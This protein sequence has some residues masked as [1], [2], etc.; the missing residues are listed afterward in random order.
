MSFKQIGFFAEIVN[1]LKEMAHMKKILPHILAA[2]ALACQVF[3]QGS[4]APETS[5]SAAAPF[6]AEIGKP[7]E[8]SFA[9]DIPDGWHIYGANP[10]ELGAP[11]QIALELPR[12]FSQTRTVWPPERPFDFMGVKSWGYSGKI[13]IR[14]EL[15]AGESAKTGQIEIPVKISMLQC[16]DTCVP[17]EKKLALKFWLENPAQSAASSRPLESSA[18]AVAPAE[19]SAKIPNLAAIILGAFAGGII[20]NLMPCVFPVIGLKIMSFASGAK[21]GQGE[22]LANAVFYTAGIVLS[23]L[24][25]G[26][27]LV[28]FKNAGEQAGW[29]FQLQNP[30]FT[31][32]AALLFFAM[33]LS[34]AGAFEMGSSLAGRAAQLE[35]AAREGANP[36]WAAA[37]GGEIAAG[38]P[39]GDG[40]KGFRP[41]KYLASFFSGVLAV[42]VASPCTAPFMGSA[43]G[44]A[45][46]A[47]ASNEE[48]FSVFAAIGLGMAFPYLLISAIPPLAKAMPRPGAWMEILKN[49]LSIPLFA[50]AIWLMWVF[51]QQTGA[52]VALASAMLVL[53][54][55]LRAFG[56][57]AQPHR[58][59]SV[60]YAGIAAAA[61][62]AAASIWIACEYSPENPPQSASVSASAPASFPT[63]AG[64][65]RTIS[66]AYS[67]SG[68]EVREWTPE[69]FAELRRAGRAVYVD[70]TA[71]WCITCQYNKRILFSPK[72]MAALKKSKAAMLV[73]DWTN[74]N[75]QIRAELEK[76]GRAGVP[77][78]IYWP[79]GADSSP[80][81]LPAILTEGALLDA[82]DKRR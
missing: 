54:V 24:A 18:A 16:A 50:S 38:T 76:Y 56:I 9:F 52:A 34:F 43:V 51:S 10:G 63:P 12:G 21:R 11:T 8:V 13:E 79:A 5:V 64:S 48:T 7:F 19:S 71:S 55:G 1:I 69:A 28:L 46:A 67:E 23:F 70:F 41:G 25:L 35:S 62:S 47:E 53:A 40:A 14:A 82:I 22:I 15:L 73:G 39:G 68:G 26:A 42:L 78:N 31:A 75:P 81:I 65:A 37:I 72:V 17:A 33:G 49:L 61:L 27:V 30:I 6:R 29:G 2:F 66:N 32:G 58:R 59:R 36:G 77:L 44:Y 74:K 3:G 80:E 60:R 45:L 57:C 4:G 20:L